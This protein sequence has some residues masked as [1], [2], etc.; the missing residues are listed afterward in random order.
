MFKIGPK[1]NSKMH[2]KPPFNWIHWKFFSGEAPQTPLHCGKRALAS[3]LI[4]LWA[5]AL[6]VSSVCFSIDIYAGISRSLKCV[7]SVLFFKILPP[8]S[9]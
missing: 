8:A 5:T 1:I 3:F 6:A 4:Y 2:Q 9:F 7:C